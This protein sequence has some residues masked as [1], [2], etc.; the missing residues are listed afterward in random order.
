MKPVEHPDRPQRPTRIPMVGDGTRALWDAWRDACL[1]CRHAHRRMGCT[2]S[3]VM[4]YENGRRFGFHLVPGGC[5]AWSP[6]R[7]GGRLV[8]ANRRRRS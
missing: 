4:E 1:G 5:S 8:L 6:R 7:D 3:G 2:S